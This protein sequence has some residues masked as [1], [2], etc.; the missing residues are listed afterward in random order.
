MSNFGAA[1]PPPTRPLRRLRLPPAPA[2]LNNSSSWSQAPNPGGERALEATKNSRLVQPHEDCRRV[3]RW[4]LPQKTVRQ[5][6]SLPSGVAKRVRA[7]AKARPTGAS[8]VLVDPNETGLE[9]RDSEKEYFFDLA[10]HFKHLR[11]RRRSPSGS[12]TNSRP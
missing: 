2:A 10:R 9:T 1:R 6:V 8:R 5:S 3:D 7:V 12:E 4:L 11:I